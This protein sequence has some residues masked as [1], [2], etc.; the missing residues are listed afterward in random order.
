MNKVV[1][2][3][4]KYIDVDNVYEQMI[5]DYPHIEPSTIK[6]V[7]GY[8]EQHWYQGKA[9]VSN[10]DTEYLNNLTTQHPEQIEVFSF[11]D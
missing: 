11:G 4:D 1:E 10:E 2:L 6:I 3:C 5:S 8:M 9:I 7:V